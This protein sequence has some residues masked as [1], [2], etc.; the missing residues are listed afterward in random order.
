MNFT[1]PSSTPLPLDILPSPLR[2]KCH[3]DKRI[4]KWKGVNPP[5]P[6]TTNDV[7]SLAREVKMLECST[8]DFAS[9]GA[10]LKKFHIFCDIFSIPESDRLPASWQIIHSFVLWA[11]ADESDASLPDPPILPQ[12]PVADSTLRHYLS[13]IRAWHIAQGWLPPLNDVERDRINLSI[14]GIARFQAGS[15][16]KPPRPPVTTA[17]LRLLKDT[18]DLNAPFDA[19]VWAIASCAFWA[20]MRLGEATVKSQAA[21]NP[22]TC[23]TRQDAL[24]EADLDGRLFVRLIIPS[25]KTARPG[26]SQSVLLVPRGTLCPIEALR[27]L[28]RVLPARASDPLFSWQDDKHVIR[29]M[30]KTRFTE[31]VNGILTANSSQRIYGHSFR[32][33]GASYYMANKIDTEVVRI[34]GRWQSMSYQVYIRNVEQVI[35]RRFA[36]LPEE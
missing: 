29:P 32:I 22:T 14:R 8:K 24:Q 2:P 35:S 17:M 25:A 3:A 31:R 19:C 21:F 34:A 13:A 36:D 27:N 23:L 28:N 26:E 9:Y 10:G 4:F 11:S 12:T 5:I 1:P 15:H 20:M 7:W 6:R 16:R 33:G 30:T 18:L